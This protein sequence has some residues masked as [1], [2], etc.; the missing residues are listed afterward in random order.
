[1]CRR[2]GIPSETLKDLRR[3]PRK[4]VN[5]KLELGEDPTPAE[6]RDARVTKGLVLGKPGS[7]SDSE[8]RAASLIFWE[9]STPHDLAKHSSGLRLKD[10]VAICCGRQ[11]PNVRAVVT[12]LAEVFREKYED[13]VTAAKAARLRFLSATLN[14]EGLPTAVRLE[15]SR[16]IADAHPDRP[17]SDHNV[18]PAA[19]DRIVDVSIVREAQRLDVRC[20]EEP[21]NPE[22]LVNPQKDLAL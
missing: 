4:L 13:A 9:H 19:L 7:P 2:L 22:K 14:D 8:S 12:A 16:Q 17:D 15:A 6:L 20:G 10:A 1:M 21:T 11:H 5:L 18:D 3:N